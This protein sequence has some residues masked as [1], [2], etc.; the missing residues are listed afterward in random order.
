MSYEVGQLVRIPVT[1]RDEA[2]AAADATM[3]VTVLREDGSAYVGL[4]VVNDPAAVGSYWVDVPVDTPGVHGWVWVASGAVVGV[5]SGQFYVRNPGVRLLSLTEAKAHLNKR[6]EDTTDDDELLDWIDTITRAVEIQVGPVVARTVVESHNGGRAELVLRYPV[7]AVTDVVEYWGP[8]D[9]R[10]L[11]AEPAG[12]P[13][14]DNQFAVNMTSRTVTRRGAGWSLMWPHGIGNIR[15]TYTA[16]RRPI[17]SNFRTAAKELLA[18]HWRASQIAQ[19][20]TRP[21]DNVPADVA[22]IGIAIPNRVKLLLGYRRA[23]MLGS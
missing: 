5:Y 7:I 18:H 4:T 3:A 17:P 10:T 2:G 23:P 14:T 13:Y 1:V 12:G 6:L 22:S 21:R 9:I 11:T 20:S 19:G 15:V 8:G 16:G